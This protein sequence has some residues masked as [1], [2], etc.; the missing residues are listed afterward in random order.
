MK[1]LKS[2]LL[3]IS[4]FSGVLSPFFVYGTGGQVVIN[5]LLYDPA[6]SDLGYEWI[7]LFNP[8]GSGI[9]LAGWK[10]QAGGSSFQDVIT[11]PG[12][13]P[14]IL[15]PG[16]FYL[17][18]EL[19]VSGANLNIDRLAFQ[20]GGSETDGI[21]ILNSSGMVIDTLLYDEP[22]VNNLLDDSGSPGINFAVDAAAGSSLGRDS[23]GSDTG[24]CA[25]DF[26][27]YTDSTPGTANQSAPPQNYSSDIV[28]NEFLPNPEGTDSDGEFIELKNIGS[29]A[30]DLANW[31]ISD[32][33]ETNYVIN[34]ADFDVTLVPVGG[35]LVV[36]R[37]VS[38]IA[39]NNSGGDQVELYQPDGILLA[40]VAYS[41]STPEG[42]S[43]ARTTSEEFDWTTTPTPGEENVFTQSN[44][45]PVADAGSNIQAA[46]SELIQ[47]DGSDSYDPDD[48]LLEYTWDFGDGATASQVAPIHSY[49][50][51]GS[52][53]AT[54]TV[55]D[56]LADNSNSITVLIQENS[57]SLPPGEYS[58]SIVINEILPNP[59]G[60]DS[61]GEFIELKNIGGEAVNLAGW[62]L[63]D[64]SA[65]RYSI[66]SDDLSSTIINPN[67]LL[68]IYRS[69]SGIA[70]NNSGGDQAALYYPNKE[71]LFL[72][73]Y[74]ES[75]PEGKSYSL[76]SSGEWV[77]TDP[78]PSAENI[79]VDNN[80][81]PVAK[82]DSVSETKVGKEVTFDASDSSDPDDDSLEYFWAFGDG[83]SAEGVETQ[84]AYN[85]LGTYS[86][87]LKV[88]DSNN[89][90]SEAST[91]ITVS[92]YDYT[93][94][95]LLN[96]LMPN[97]AGSD[98]EGEWI[99]IV[100][101]EGRTVN[102]LGWQVT[103][104]KDTY[105]FAD[106]SLMESQ[107]YW[108]ISRS[109]SGITLNNAGDTV[110]LINPRG[111]VV[112]GV[113]YGKASEDIAFARQDF[114]DNWVWTDIPTPGAT[115]EIRA[116]ESEED[117]SDNSES[118]TA[119][120][121]AVVTNLLEAKK[122]EKGDLV[123]VEGWVTVEP[124]IL[125]S[126]KF[127]LAQD[128]GGIQIYSSK[129]DFPELSLGD[130]IQVTGKLSEASGE[131]KI[132]ISSAEDI[133]I[134]EPQE[135]VPEPTIITSEEIGESLEGALV[136][137][138]GNLVDKKG[139][140]FY[141]DYGGPGEAKIAIKS[142][143]GIKKPALEDGQLIRVTGI[144]SQSGDEYQIL[145]RYQ[146]DIVLPAVLG[147]SQESNQVT[148]VPPVS[149]SKQLWKYIIVLV[150]GT[151][152]VGAGL[153]KKK[154]GLWG[155]CKKALAKSS[156]I[157]SS[158]RRKQDSL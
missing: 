36:D 72:V 65:A 158:S 76:L 100:N 38:G 110:Y 1:K 71:E 80:H 61:E 136:T 8:S 141:L 26:Q 132:N 31:I 20:N 54:L 142:S 112:S 90:F 102:L 134:L 99:E 152:A 12:E 29:Q 138:E 47:F 82:I 155:K 7:E 113:S 137:V 74:S 144:V 4:I 50:T 24:N 77:W 37:S 128:Q 122:L 9:N 40:E 111:E 39:L 150:V 27:E 140:N 18:G 2:L 146:E 48:D 45:P 143:T 135:I 92:D 97:V 35:F 123:Q 14:I 149:E 105:T 101:L 28:I 103:D 145:P 153:L 89:A 21:R 30:E 16:G 124:G 58:G 151:V 15:N 91:I 85:E 52:Y 53:V 34:P 127:Y 83:N 108:L 33:S 129:K 115:N 126:Q 68:V 13:N 23:L 116:V 78:T 107:G 63:G 104:L 41:G 51:A 60:S 59:E 117:S 42:E 5:E 96:E 147:E 109:D 56:G 70:L 118:A 130:Y 157:T 148:A 73:E 98:S 133:V 69:A 119:K 131:K 120:K 17:I 25:L 84:H 139:S 22:N 66:N 75:A 64:S 6:G 49:S 94:K 95:I 106:D 93:E 81:P 154:Y 114:S 156:G 86:V 125:G 10:I 43:F 44:Q 87:A 57:D 19:E 62:Q 46:M 32:S 79:L 55:D 88:V 3:L 11:I 121:A 67:G